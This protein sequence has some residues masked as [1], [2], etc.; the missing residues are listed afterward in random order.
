VPCNKVATT[1]GVHFSWVLVFLHSALA[2]PLKALSV[3]QPVP[4]HTYHTQT[5]PPALL[6]PLG[7]NDVAVGPTKPGR[8]RARRSALPMCLCFKAWVIIS[9]I[10]QNHLNLRVLVVEP[11]TRECQHWKPFCLN[12]A[13]L[14]GVEKVAREQQK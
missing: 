7:M 3:T 9:H 10:I 11:L 4:A 5:F 8:N 14:M 1:T 13:S 2:L 12:K 6:G